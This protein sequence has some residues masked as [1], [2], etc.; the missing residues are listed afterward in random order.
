MYYVAGA[1]LLAQVGLMWVLDDSVDLEGLEYLA[2]AV[3]L[4]GVALLVASILTLRHRGQASEGRSYV[5]TE[6]LISTGVY[7]LVRHPLY[8]GWMVMYVAMVL[9]K[10]NWIL[11]LAG[12]TGSVCVY[13][14]AVQ[15]EV[16][17]KE[18]FGA[19][20]RRYMEAVPRFNLAAG[21]IRFLLRRRTDSRTS[22]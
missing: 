1:L 12:I 16:S 20:Y 22:V 8:L 10:P 7:G 2:G 11:A 3:W 6:A 17:L 15:E 19:S 14:I 5:E 4:V 18:K 13:W 21:A 9:L